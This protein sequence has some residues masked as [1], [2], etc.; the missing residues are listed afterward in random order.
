MGVWLP[1]S[2]CLPS[3]S[4]DPLLPP[5]PQEEAIRHWA[6]TSAYRM[7]LARARSHNPEEVAAERAR[8]MRAL[9]PLL[10]HPGPKLIVTDSQVRLAGV[11]GGCRGQTVVGMG[12]GV[13]L[14][15]EEVSSARLERDPVPQGEATA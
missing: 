3:P 14:C 2:A 8:F 7:D 15:R 13:Q 5:P 1:L 12:C 10:A 4:P 11:R 9:Q 6:S